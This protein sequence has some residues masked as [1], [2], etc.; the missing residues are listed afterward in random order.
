MCCRFLTCNC[1][2]LLTLLH[3]YLYATIMC[4]WFLKTHVLLLL[5]NKCF[6]TGLEVQFNIQF[7]FIT[8]NRHYNSKIKFNST[9]KSKAL[10]KR[11]TVNRSVTI[12]EWTYFLPVT[13]RTFFQALHAIAL[14]CSPVNKGSP[15]DFCDF[16]T[17]VFL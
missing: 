8:F 16:A 2:L 3:V 5:L 13:L 6:F 11:N 14:R 17:R 9:W 4:N 10:R 12:F 15:G 1:L 7:L